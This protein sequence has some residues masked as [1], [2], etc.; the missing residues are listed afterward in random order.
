MAVGKVNA[1]HT[2]T[3][4]TAV[5][6]VT[7]AS[8]NLQ[9]QLLAKQQN[10]KKVTK[11]SSLSLEE[12]E[13]QRQ[14]L[15]KEIEELKRRLEQIRLKAKET[16][17]TEKEIAEVE[18]EK[19]IEETKEEKKENVSTFIKKEESLK[20]QEQISVEDVQKIL[21]HNLYLKDEMVEQGVA[22]DKENTVRILNAEIH[23]DELRG[24]DTSSKK[25]KVKEIQEKQN[26]WEE[27]KHKR[28][29]E[30]KSR[31]ISADMQ[32]IIS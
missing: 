16:E 29:E 5:Q 13:K 26:F 7:S 14:K 15:E 32:V 28:V 10:L 11:D 27:S 30:E 17:K 19:E 8:K 21:H 23:Q 20:Q 6:N 31:I 1:I 4:T 18:S 12:K 2:I 9:N 24:L 25:E 22:Y 3:G